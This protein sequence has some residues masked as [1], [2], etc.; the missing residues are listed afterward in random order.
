VAQRLLLAKCP[1]DAQQSSQ[2]QQQQQYQACATL[3]RAGSLGSRVAGAVA[4]AAGQY[5]LPGSGGFGESSLVWRP[6]TGVDRGMLDVVPRA[7][8]GTSSQLPE[9]SGRLNTGATSQSPRSLR[10]AMW[11]GSTSRVVGRGA[12]LVFRGLR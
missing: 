6:S 1:D 12:I 9:L 2:P 3:G 11:G 10:D 7:R 5:G 8:S 4:R